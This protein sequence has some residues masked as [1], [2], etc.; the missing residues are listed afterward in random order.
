MRLINTL[1]VNVGKGAV[2]VKR[3]GGGVGKYT[4]KE[5]RAL[6]FGKTADALLETKRGTKFL[7]ALAENKKLPRLKE[8]SQLNKL[9]DNILMLLTKLDDPQDIKRVLKT[10]LDSEN[11]NMRE[12]RQIPSIRKALNELG[13]L[14]EVEAWDI[15][16]SAGAFN[17]LPFQQ[18][19]IPQTFN[20][21][22]K[23]MSGGKTDVAKNLDL[24][25]VRSSLSKLSEV[26]SSTA[27]DD[28]F[29]GVVGLGSE[30][31][32][33]AP[34]KLSRWFD[35]APKRRLSVHNLGE[36][37]NNL[38]YLMKSGRLAE[39]RMHELLDRTLMSQTQGELDD[40]Y[41]EVLDEIGDSIVR[42]NPDL[43]GSEP[44]MRKAMKFVWDETMELKKYF[45]NE[46]GKSM[47]FQ[48]SKQRSVP[49]KFGDATQAIEAAPTAM[50]IS[51]FM[52]SGT[53]M[54]DYMEIE[55][56]DNQIKDILK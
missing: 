14:S 17:K 41:K 10:L 28:V 25:L 33:L 40:I 7:Q 26:F 51:Q 37:S 34:Q 3:V 47:F 11:L 38:Y 21:L 42:A 49:D 36:S 32:Y 55:K 19:L 31:R 43:R 8:V 27:R 22:L 35:L 48:G 1:P 30:A 29:N 16:Q 54:I 5:A 9:D 56:T 44:E 23:A 52:D 2:R 24:S 4:A 50:L 20:Q 13:S 18:N 45:V 39:D 15:A 6:Q 53:Q 46:D 12:L